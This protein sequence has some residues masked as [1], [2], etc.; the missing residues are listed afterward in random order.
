MEII[1]KYSDHGNIEWK[2]RDKQMHVITIAEFGK[3]VFRT[4]GEFIGN[5]S[6]EVL[7]N[8][9]DQANMMYGSITLYPLLNLSAIARKYLRKEMSETDKMQFEIIIRNIIKLDQECIKSKH[10]LFDFTC[11]VLN[12]D[13]ITE[14]IS[15][16][17]KEL[18]QPNSEIEICEIWL[19]NYTPDD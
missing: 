1:T 10:L 13:S 9:C 11:A 12:K 18:I 5:I 16:V 7:R 8:Y 15:K 2:L 4:Y 14:C 19:D 6:H 3:S 17:A